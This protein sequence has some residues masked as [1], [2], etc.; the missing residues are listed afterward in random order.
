M[1]MLIFSDKLRAV[2]IAEPWET[3]WNR[4]D[5]RYSMQHLFT[6]LR[7]LALPHYENTFPV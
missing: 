4:S 3:A 5:S 7:L 2:A 1:G 6:Q